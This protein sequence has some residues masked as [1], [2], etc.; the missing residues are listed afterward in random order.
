MVKGDGCFKYGPADE[1][2]A[3]HKKAGEKI[4][5]KVSTEAWLLENQR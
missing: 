4:N 2:V 3:V 5:G 1:S